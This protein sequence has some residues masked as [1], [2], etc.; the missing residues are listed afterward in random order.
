MDG[1][2]IEPVLGGFVNI[3]YEN[4]KRAVTC[5]NIVGITSRRRPIGWADGVAYMTVMTNS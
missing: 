4:S 1:P 2:L 3:T 5:T